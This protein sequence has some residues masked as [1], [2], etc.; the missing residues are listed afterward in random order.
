M[1]KSSHRE[2]IYARFPRGA[3]TGCRHQHRRGQ[4]FGARGPEAARYPEAHYKLALALHQD[5]KEEESRIEFE[6][7]S[8][9]SRNASPLNDVFP[10]NFDVR[11]GDAGSHSCLVGIGVRISRT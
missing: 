4:I 7:A 5:G 6:G 1:G 9:I 8:E 2:G 10:E 3:A 11:D